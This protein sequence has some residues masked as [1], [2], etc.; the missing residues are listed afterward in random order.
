M[1]RCD[2]A[3]YWNPDKY[4]EC[5]HCAKLERRRLKPRRAEKPTRVEKPA[6]P[7]VRLL[8]AS[9]AVQKNI[10]NAEVLDEAMQIYTQLGF[11]PANASRRAREVLAAHPEVGTIEQFMQYAFPS[12]SG[13]SI[14]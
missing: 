3:H 4:D 6:Q 9:T 11:L 8:P 1:I 14:K 2:N 5:V 12:N 13:R 10:L 7:V